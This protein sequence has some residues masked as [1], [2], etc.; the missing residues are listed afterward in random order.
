MWQI[1]PERSSGTANTSPRIT[2]WELYSEKYNITVPL[3]IYLP[4]EL[5]KVKQVIFSIHGVERNA[6][7]YRDIFIRGLKDSNILLVAPEF[8]DIKLQHAA[9]LSLGNMY[10]STQLTQKN[11]R[12]LWTFTLIQSVF[13]ELKKIFTDIEYYDIFGHSA[14]AQFAHRYAF[15]GDGENVRKIVAANAGWYTVLDPELSM[16]Y[17][18]KGMFDDKMT[19]QILARKLIIL[20]GKEDTEVDKHLRISRRANLQGT[21]RLERAQNFYETA[22]QL[23]R[24]LATPCNWEFEVLEAVKHRSTQVVNHALRHLLQP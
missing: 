16:P 14:G 4:K 8:A 11:E 22:I 20:A 7:K 18:T 1:L 21:N 19:K 6:S 23:S 24:A 3:H 12:E 5:H 10:D 17:G 15:F 9:A 13:E 2:T